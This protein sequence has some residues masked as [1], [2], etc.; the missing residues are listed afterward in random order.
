VVLLH[1]AG[2]KGKDLPNNLAL[3]M[4][5]AKAG[6]STITID[7]PFFGERATD[8]L[9][10]YSDEEKHG[11]L[12]NQPGVYLAWMTQSVR[13]IRRAYDV[14]IQKGV[15][16]GRVALVGASRGAIAGTI[17]AGVDRRFSPVALLFA[18]HATPLELDHVEA[19]CPA[20]YI[21][22]IA[23]RPLFMLNSMND[24]TFPPGLAVKPLFALAGG[25]KQIIWTGGGHMVLTDT[26]VA[27]V[28]GWLRGRLN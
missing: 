23:P 14:L 26:D 24:Q 18:G 13:D 4:L 2:A 28:V 17:A 15:D 8:L 10:A 1:S 3:A 11:Q 9:T 16:S 20:N 5:M 22:H 27:A 12:Y 19:V 25:P 7:L 6:W 21:A